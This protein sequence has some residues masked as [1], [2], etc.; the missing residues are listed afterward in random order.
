MPF[1]LQ[2]T[3]THQI[4]SCS[5][6]NGYD[7][8]YYGVKSWEN[9]DMA[10]AEL[11]SFLDAQRFELDNL[12]KLIEIDEHVLKMCNVKARNDSRYLIFL[13]EN[14]RPYATLKL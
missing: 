10:N 8:P 12:W 5:L 11:S 2:H 3:E 1:V 4:Y 13:D 14:G 7:L 6:I 9:E